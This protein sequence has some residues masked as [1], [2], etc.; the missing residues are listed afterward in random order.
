MC[1]PPKIK[2]DCDVHAETCTMCNVTR[3]GMI[4]IDYLPIESQLQNLMRSKSYSEK[5]LSLWRNKDR[6][7]GK[8][9]NDA[10]IYIKD[11]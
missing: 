4:P 8:S 2:R 3:K 1:N 11:F 7:I 9:A 10:P 5:M 6:W